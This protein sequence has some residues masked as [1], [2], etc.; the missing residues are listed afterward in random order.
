MPSAVAAPPRSSLERKEGRAGYALIAPTS[1]LLALFYL[2]PLV[3]TVGYSFTNWNPATGVAGDFVGLDNFAGLL[4][5]DEFLQAAGNTALYVVIVVPVTMILGLFFAALLAQPFRGRGVYRALLFVPYIAPIVGSA[6]IFSFILSPLGG[7]VNG[8]ITAL[9]GPPI[10]FLNSEPWALVSVMV[11]SVWQGVGY[12][13]II[14]SAALTN[15]PASYHEAATLDGAGPIRRFFT[16]SLPLVAPTTGFLAVTGVIGALQ[17]FTQVYV[18][19]QGGPL[20]STETILYYIYQQGFVFFHGGSASAAAVVLLLVGIVVA[21]IQ[22]RF[23]N[24]RDPI[25]LT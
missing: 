1:I 22:L 3:Q 23:I 5:D 18:L 12:A 8:V 11:F 25:E 21:V 15:I 20:G 6:L 4:R 17:V 24:R 16:I 10:G 14:Y 7:I 13:M 9:G 19:T 2:Y